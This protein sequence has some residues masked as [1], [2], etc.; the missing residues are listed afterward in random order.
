MYFNIISIYFFWHVNTLVIL[1]SYKTC[2]SESCYMRQTM[3]HCRE[4]TRTQNT[5]KSQP[6]HTNKLPELFFLK[7]GV[8]D[9]CAEHHLL[10][11]RAQQHSRITLILYMV[12]FR[13]S[14]S[15]THKNTKEP[16]WYIYLCLAM[17]WCSVYSINTKSSK[18][19]GGLSPIWMD[20]DH[21]DACH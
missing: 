16:M 18:N 8:L 14:T 11:I 6:W 12:K 21:E 13:A 10:H 19:K 2:V 9:E 3:R 1:Y 17:T 20:D 15:Q 5:Q 4:I 7:W